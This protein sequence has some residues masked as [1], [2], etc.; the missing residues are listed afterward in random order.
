MIIYWLLNTGQFGSW[1]VKGYMYQNVC[2]IFIFICVNAMSNYWNSLN[3]IDMTCPGLDRSRNII[4]PTNH[5]GQAEGFRDF[6]SSLDWGFKPNSLIVYKLDYINPS[7]PQLK[8]LVMTCI[9]C[10]SREMVR[11]KLHITLAMCRVF[12]I[13]MHSQANILVW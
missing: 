5:H 1:K 3:D 7:T 9:K 6:H 2:S 12:D 4:L 10:D 11:G 13:D 8:Y